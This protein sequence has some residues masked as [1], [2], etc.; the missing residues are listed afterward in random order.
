MGQQCFSSMKNQKKLLL[1][2]YKILSIS[3]KNGNAKLLN[4]LNSSENEYSKLATKKW[5]VIDSETKGSYSHHDSIKRLTGTLKSSLCD[6]SDTYILV[7][8]DIPVK[9][10]NAANT[11]DTELAAATQVAFKIWAPFKE[12]RTEINDTFVDYADFY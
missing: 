9:R 12:C 2:F 3:Y 10:R 11:A 7:T 6:Y 1:S 5:Y 8:G 4:L